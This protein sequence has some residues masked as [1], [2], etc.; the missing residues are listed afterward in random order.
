[1]SKAISRTQ[2]YLDN[3]DTA[4]AKIDRALTDAFVSA[5]PVYVM[6]PSD[7]VTKHVSGRKSSRLS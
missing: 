6:I 1:M 3:V 7:V 2:V 4:P 5:R